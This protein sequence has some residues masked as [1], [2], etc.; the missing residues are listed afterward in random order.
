MDFDV[1]IIGS[2]IAGLTTAF[3][4]AKTEKKVAVVESTTFGGVVYNTGST[5]KKELVTLAQHMLQNNQW[6][7]QGITT[8]VQMDWNNAMNWIN[9]I[10]NM[11]DTQHQRSLKEAGIVTIY[12]EAVFISPNEI[13]V[14]GI[15]YTAEQYVIT[16]GAEDRPFT[17]EGHEYLS[18]S[19]EFLT[20]KDLPKEVLFIGAGII[21]FAFATIATAFGCKVRILQYNERAL[22]DFDQEF[23]GQ[24]VEI[25]KKRGVQVNFNES[26]E[27]ILSTDSG[28]LMVQTISGNTFNTQKVFNVA[29]RI[30]RIQ[31][32]SLD[33]AGVNYD[34]HGILTNEYLQTTQPHIFACGDCSNAAVPKLATF[35]SY[36]G[37]Y[38]VSHMTNKNLAP[39]RYP[40]AAVSIF[41]EPR[42][43][44]VGVTTKEALSAPEE[45]RIEEI[46]SS[47]WL[48]SKR[49]S[50]SISLLKL[51]IRR[52]D[53]HIV[54][55]TALNQEA[56]VLINEITMV[57]HAGWTKSELKN[58]ILAYPSLAGELTRFWK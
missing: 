42:I 14:D 18:S 54:G 21:S 57:L 5:R 55:A 44:Q 27:K 15:T 26:I 9:S 4:L 56:D 7:K 53:E 37:E 36:Q 43:A 48:E 30:P 16:T 50:E 33:N 35:A 46:D 58:Q 11:E 3:G 47:D 38:L 28:E 20:Q 49:K 29:G 17:F 6:E 41:S 31:Q 2:G 40:L 32:L 22:K 39:I 51:I 13:K 19:S 23:V 1:I 8:P 10:E 34:D 24:L 25:N 45:F 12:G 52:S